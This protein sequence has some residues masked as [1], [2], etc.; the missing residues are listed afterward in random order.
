MRATP[1][2][3]REIQGRAEKRKSPFLNNLL[4]SGIFNL[5]L[6]FRSTTKFETL[7]RKKIDESRLNVR[8]VFVYDWSISCDL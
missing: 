2:D 1:P 4:S 5:P 7:S 6:N 8:R 3:S